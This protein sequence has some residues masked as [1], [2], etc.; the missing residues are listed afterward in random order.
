MK[1]PEI[2][3]CLRLE[4]HPMKKDDGPFGLLLGAVND[5]HKDTETLFKTLQSLYPQIL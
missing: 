5:L 2:K 4:L 3:P 1:R